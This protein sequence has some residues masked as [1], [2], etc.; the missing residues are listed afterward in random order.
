MA[1]PNI[2]ESVYIFKLL[3]AAYGFLSYNPLWLELFVQIPAM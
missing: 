3:E 2:Y 1:D